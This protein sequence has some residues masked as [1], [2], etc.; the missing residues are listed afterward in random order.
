[1]KVYDFALDEDDMTKLDGLNRDLRVYAEPMWVLIHFL[2]LKII[3]FIGKL[4]VKWHDQHSNSL[5]LVSAVWWWFIS[6]IQLIT[7]RQTCI[8]YQELSIFGF[9][10][11]AFNFKRCSLDAD[12]VLWQ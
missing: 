7:E 5:P 1:M 10:G 11:L 12:I 8:N 2:Q 6:K 3:N 9:Y 4:L